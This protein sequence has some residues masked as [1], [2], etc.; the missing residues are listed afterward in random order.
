[1]APRQSK[2]SN[3]PRSRNADGDHVIFVDSRQL[4]K[5]VGAKDLR[6]VLGD[7]PRRAPK[8]SVK[9]DAIGK[10]NPKKGARKGGRGGNNKKKAPANPETL[11]KELAE[12]M[13]DDVQ[14]QR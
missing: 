4:M 13:G 5:A 12:Y 1:M 8:K 11:E 2:K 3:R 6:E 10:P 14:G 7:S 9:R